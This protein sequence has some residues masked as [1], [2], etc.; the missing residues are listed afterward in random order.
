MF[1]N[2]VST[3]PRTDAIEQLPTEFLFES[4]HQLCTERR[5]RKMQFAAG[6]TNASFLGDHPK[7]EQV[8]IIQP[9]ADID[10]YCSVSFMEQTS[11]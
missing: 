6:T 3:T 5:L 10:I 1:P 4:D 7:I 9:V 11:I 2:S 8:M